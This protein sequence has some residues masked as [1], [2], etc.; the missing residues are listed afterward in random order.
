MGCPNLS[1]EKDKNYPLLSLPE[2][3]KMIHHE[4][5]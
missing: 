5:P 2:N 1:L 4:A 3:D